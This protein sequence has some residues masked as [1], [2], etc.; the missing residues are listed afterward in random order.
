MSEYD[1]SQFR[2][3]AS[4]D[5]N[6]SQIER[7]IK[8]YEK[9]KKEKEE[10]EK[11]LETAKKLVD[12]FETQDIPSA[13]QDMGISKFTTSEG[14]E[15]KCET[16]IRAS[17]PKTNT[18]PALNWLIANGHEGLIKQELKVNLPRNDFAKADELVGIIKEHHNEVDRKMSV[19][20]QTLSK[21][22]RDEKEK[23]NS[24]PDDLFSVF[25]QPTTKINY[26]KG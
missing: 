5:K 14:V 20:P 24:V 26:P 6:L 8:A 21:F 16:V 13:L 9:A 15:V 12:R 10:C 18:I 4:D 17:I 3:D 11:K 23:G 7:L 22:V 1:W 2:E 25:E 19:H